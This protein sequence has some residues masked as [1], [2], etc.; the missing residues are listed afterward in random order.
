MEEL[1]ELMMME[2]LL[3]ALPH[4]VRIWVVERGPKTVAELGKLADTYDQAQRQLPEAARNEQG[5]KGK[6]VSKEE[7][8]RGE[9]RSSQE[10]RQ[11][12]NCGMVGHIARDCRRGTK[13]SAQQPE[14]A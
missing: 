6:V 11:C 2:Q 3:N 8:K 5:Q 9:W 1:K 14:Q 7:G 12:H 4:K 13:A 10:I